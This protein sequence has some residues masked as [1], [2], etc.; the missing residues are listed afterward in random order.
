MW[1]SAP[2]DKLEGAYVFAEGFCK[3][4]ASCGRTESSAPTP[5]LRRAKG[6]PWAQGAD[7]PYQGEMARRAKEG[8]DAGPKGLRGFERRRFRTHSDSCDPSP[9]SF[10]SNMPPPLPVRDTARR[11]FGV[12]KSLSRGGRG[13]LY[14]GDT[15]RSAHYP[16]NAVA[17]VVITI[18]T[19][20]LVPKTGSVPVE[21]SPS[22]YV[23]YSTRLPSAT[24]DIT[25]SLY[26]ER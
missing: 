15:M 14:G 18:F 9:P 10:S 19:F 12:R 7:S 4:G 26:S 21:R 5:I 6:S 8:R 20:A 22:M 13:F 11:G 17:A 25:I 23:A 24:A 16:I 3:I 2:T 1:A